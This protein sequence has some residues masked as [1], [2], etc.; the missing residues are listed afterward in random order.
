MTFPVDW[1]TGG[2]LGRLK[3]S[4]ERTK[5]VQFDSNKT[6]PSERLGGM[7]G[8]SAR[9]GD[10]ATDGMKVESAGW[11]MARLEQAGRS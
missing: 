1:A 3:P 8:V 9:N 6:M 5:T 10:T 4:K 7:F 11:P 2:M